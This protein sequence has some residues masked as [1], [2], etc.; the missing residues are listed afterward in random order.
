MTMDVEV[1]LL[2]H[3]AVLPGLKRQPQRAATLVPAA[4]TACY[5]LDYSQQ[6]DSFTSRIHEQ[7][8]FILNMCYSIHNHVPNT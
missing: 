6:K 2:H 8:S 7:R 3:V 5:R 1:L 4:D